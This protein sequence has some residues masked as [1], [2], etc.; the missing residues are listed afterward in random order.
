MEKNYYEELMQKY[1]NWK[2]LVK[3]LMIDRLENYKDQKTYTCDLVYTL[4]ESENI[5]GSFTYNC[6][7]SKKLI[8]KYWDDFNEIYANYID[9]VGIENSI[10]ILDEPEKF[11]VIM[12]LEQGNDLLNCSNDFINDNWNE[13]ITLNNKNIKKITD[14]LT[15]A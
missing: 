8:Q 12:L 14:I 13:Q 1:E 5:D 7:W 10:N 3:N 4:F 15:E 9:N 6:Y 2:D 11:V